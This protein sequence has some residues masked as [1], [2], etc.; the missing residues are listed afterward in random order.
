MTIEKAIETLSERSYELS[1]AE[2]IKLLM[3]VFNLPSCLT[4][5][6]IMKLEA[7]LKEFSL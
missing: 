3:V 2:R 7:L 4:V 1:E 6:E 5:L